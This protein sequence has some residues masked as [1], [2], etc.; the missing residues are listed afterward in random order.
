MSFYNVTNPTS[1]SIVSDVR[2]LLVQPGK[3]VRFPQT[4][5]F[6]GASG[7]IT[8][9]LTAEQLVAG[10]IIGDTTDGALTLTLPSATDLIT[11]LMGPGGFDV[12]SS[13]IFSF[14]ATNIAS[15]N[16]LVFAV[17][18]GGSGSNKTITGSSGGVTRTINLQIV[19]S[20]S[21]GSTSYSYIML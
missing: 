17:G 16:N 8:R 20:V 13:D 6:T 3:L 2:K 21:G 9:A 12:S 4:Q 19:I 7:G 1:F 10:N 11:L 14:T 15:S 5:S 18:T